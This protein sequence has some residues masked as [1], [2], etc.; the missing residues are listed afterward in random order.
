M[1]LLPDVKSPAIIDPGA[2]TY[3]LYGPPGVGKTSFCAKLDNAV[4]IDTE[5]G[6]KL[7]SLYK[8]P[9]KDWDTFLKVVGELT[10]DKHNFKT[11]VIDTVGNLLNFCVKYCCEK[12]G[13]THPSEMG[14]GK[15][16]D[17]I[18]KTF[19]VPLVALQ[20]SG[21][22]LWMIS[23]HQV[24]KIENPLGADYDYIEP[25]APDY[26]KNILIAAC[27]FVFYANTEA[28]KTLDE[29]T[30]KIVGVREGTVLTTKPSK[31]ILAKD[32]IVNCP[33]PAKI[34]LKTSVFLEALKLC[35]T[36]NQEI[37]SNV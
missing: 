26:L 15:S 17:V 30:G 5:Q 1:G 22:G 34:E 2:F 8:V 20:H 35:L 4:F 16:Y 33:L 7:Q 28:I 14:Y 31:G 6:T 32:R 9:V 19:S 23:H 21:L 3:L 13:I 37:L 25:A 18:K 36:K 12:L 11:V 10:K 24:K 29:S 27:D